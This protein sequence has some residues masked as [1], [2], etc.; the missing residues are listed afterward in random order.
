MRLFFLMYDYLPA[1][2]PDVSVLFGKELKQLGIESDLFGQLKAGKSLAEG[3]AWPAGVAHVHGGEETEL[4]GQ[5][6]RPL[7]DLALLR[8]LEP[9]HR[10]IQ[11]RD[12]IRTGL[13]ALW[14][15]RLTGR[16]MTYWMSFPFA[17]GFKVR[18]EQ[19]GA[20]QG[21]G[22]QLFYRL[23]AAC[24]GHIYYKWLAPRVD[25]LFVQSDAML[26]FMAVKGVPRGRMTAVP[27]GVDLAL[28]AQG[29]NLK[30]RPPQMTD[31][32]VLAYLG[33]LGQSRHSQFLLE[34]LQQVRLH[35]HNAMLLLVG[36]GASPDEQQWIRRSIADSGLSEH[37]WLTGWLPQS[38]GLALLR[39]ADIGLSPIPRGEL[40][41]VSSPTKAAEYL[42]LGLP[43]VGN[44]I[45]DQRLVIDAS[46]GGICVPMDVDAFAAACLRIFNDPVYARA[47][48]EAG[49]RW[50]AEHRSYETLAKNVASVYE[51]LCRR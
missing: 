21:L 4:A 32:K 36:D 23:R 49:K 45:P 15:A 42:A 19:V 16:K 8:L 47:C 28:F 18:A 48:G 20:S 34:V 9:E 38:E 37:V 30:P 3:R 31:R 1:G 14:I 33:T 35:E 43:C 50:V 11:V 46:S 6:R 5:L 25:H 51:G 7:H 44:D 29:Q 41:D 10:I 24:A 22:K 2:R 12:K 17:E 40:F 26:E 27:M 13:L 39:H